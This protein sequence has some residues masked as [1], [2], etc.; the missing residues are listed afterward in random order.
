MLGSGL[1]CFDV[2]A[3]LGNNNDVLLAFSFFPS[4]V[5]G[6]G[7][8]FFLADP[9]VFLPSHMQERE[10]M[11]KIAGIKNRSDFLTPRQPAAIGDLW[12]LSFPSKFKLM[13]A[14]ERGG[15]WDWI[16]CLFCFQL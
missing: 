4:A 10:E 11:R 5:G 3:F 8:L 16:G 7:S 15:E 6:R 12:P 1:R 2:S 14:D 9:V 13:P